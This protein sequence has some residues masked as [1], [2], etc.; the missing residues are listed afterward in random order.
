MSI[1]IPSENGEPTEVAV[2]GSLPEALP[3]L[4]LRDSVPFPETL[5]PLAIGGMVI[6]VLGVAM[7]T[8]PART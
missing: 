6:T 1:H 8:R 5:T 4:P 3:I 2:R 7:A